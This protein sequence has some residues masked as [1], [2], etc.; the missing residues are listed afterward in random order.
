MH[1]TKF[2][3][4]SYRIFIQQKIQKYMLVCILALIINLLKLQEVGQY[5]KILKKN[6]FVFFQ[7]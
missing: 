1:T 5:F 2:K 3:K 7:Y 4:K 6:H